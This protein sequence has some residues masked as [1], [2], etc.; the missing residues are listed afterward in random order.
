MICLNN[1]I[2]MPDLRRLSAATAGALAAVV[3]LLAAGF[4]LLAATEGPAAQ[5][6]QTARAALERRD[7][8]AAEI[9]AKQALELGA[10]RAAV[11]ALVG[12]GELLQGDLHDAREWLG[13]GQF[14]PENHERG[15]HALARLEIA[16]GN[17]A[18][19]AEA[20]DRVLEQADGSALLWV[21]IARMRYSSGEHHRALDAA[22]RAVGRDSSEPRALEL[23][24]QLARDAQ[25]L[26]ASLPWFVRALQSAPDDLGLL[27][28]YAAT[29]G[30]MGRASDMLAVARR[31]VEIN[32]SHPRAYFLQ[33]VL[34]A[35]AGRDDLARK[36]LWRSNGAFDHTPAGLLLS[37][38]LELRSGNAALAVEQFDALAKRQPYNNQ[39]QLLLG[40]ALLANNEANEVVA[41]LKPLADRVDAAPYLL[42][43]VGRAYEHLGQRELAAPYL[44]RA[45]GAMPQGFHNLPPLQAARNFSRSQTVSLR[46]GGHVT[47][48]RSLLAQGMAEEASS[49]AASLRQTFPNSIDI[50]VLA[51]DVALLRGDA[52]YALQNYQSAAV[53]RR[54]WPVVQRMVEAFEQLGRNAEAEQLLAEHLRQHPRD[55]AAA[56]QLARLWAQQRRGG[57]AL[58]LLRH[59][60][61][62]AGHARDPRLLAMVSGA[63]LQAGNADKALT[64]ARDAYGLQRSNGPVAAVLARVLES[65]GNGPASGPRALAAKAKSV[66][67]AQLALR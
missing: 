2:C 58:V 44:D 52:A 12:E 21:D 49:L 30:E 27:G 6:M 57:E 11:A 20:F 42:V 14:D 46:A 65:A 47:Q 18:A 37:G 61:A 62:M 67:S 25:G 56:M 4:P 50:E 7:G 3:V 5:A 55:A 13:P 16:E 51:G 63:E 9:A 28:E 38:V 64:M 26:E 23:R 40:R 48:I 34:A 17:L 66:Q 53:I 32:P 10:P 31:M 45:A 43:L 24:A 33:A 41:R 39:A 59:V 8:I 22:T 60:T 1:M 19:A 36:L 29:L 15:F 35:R 54:E